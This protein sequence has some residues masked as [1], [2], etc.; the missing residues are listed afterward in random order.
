MQVFQ[1]LLLDVGCAGVS[2]FYFVQ[3][4]V[5]LTIE[6][7]A[8]VGDVVSVGVV[9]GPVVM[10]VVRVVILSVVLMVVPTTGVM[11][12]VEEVSALARADVQAPVHRNLTKSC[13]ER[14]KMKM[15]MTQSLIC[16]CLLLLGYA[17]HPVHHLTPGVASEVPGVGLIR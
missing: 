6:V 1:H 12:V 9:V 8:F 15:M 14:K 10:R 11:G 17:L 7:S 16:A 5:G 4:L 13:W 3:C 2:G